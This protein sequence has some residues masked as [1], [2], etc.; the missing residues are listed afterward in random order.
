MLNI[1]LARS[2]TRATQYIHLYMAQHISVHLYGIPNVSFFA[3]QKSQVQL[4]SRMF[5][6][7]VSENSA[8]TIQKF[9]TCSN[10]GIF[11]FDN[12]TRLKS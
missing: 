8:L 12:E 7:C 10:D 9:A 2:L 4:L 5:C 6:E 3:L 11:F 1:P